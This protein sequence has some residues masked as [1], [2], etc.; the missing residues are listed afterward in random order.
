MSEICLKF[1]SQGQ[2][3]VKFSNFFSKINKKVQ[4]N[5]KTINKKADKNSTPGSKFLPDTTSILSS[6]NSTFQ[7]LNFQ[8]QK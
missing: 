7:K 8:P 5:S 3:L 2:I 6:V 4:K 1:G